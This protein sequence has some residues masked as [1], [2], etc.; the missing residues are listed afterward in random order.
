M[1]ETTANENYIMIVSLLP[2]PPINLLVV[3]SFSD[4]TH[5]VCK[6]TGSFYNVI[7]GS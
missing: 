6:P 2:L 3:V 5:V 4:F 7:P 1:N